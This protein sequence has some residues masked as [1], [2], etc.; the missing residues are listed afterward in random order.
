MKELKNKIVV[1]V[2]H[3]GSGKTNFAVNL[4]L[5][6][7]D[8][9]QTVTMCDLDVVNPYFRSS[10]FSDMLIERGVEII[11]PAFAGSNLDVPALTG[12]LDGA[13]GGQRGLVIDVGGDD[14]G[15]TA[16]GRYAARILQETATVVYVVNPHRP[17]TATPQQALEVLREIE[18]ASHLKA[19]HIVANPNLGTQTTPE[20]V[21]GSVSYMQELSRLCALPISCTAVDKTIIDKVS[22]NI[23]GE[24]MAVDVFVKPPWAVRE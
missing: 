18:T 3:Y 23:A 22:G 8:A 1:V 12:A 13:I 10:D 14:V 19:T 21:C 6:R 2:G 20:I 7:A 16:L 9:G 4:A 15:A 24:V 11:A 5:H 17:E